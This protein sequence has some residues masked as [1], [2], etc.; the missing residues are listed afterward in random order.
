MKKGAGLV[1]IDA[2]SEFSKVKSV[3]T[4]LCDA[5][6]RTRDAKD[7]LMDARD[8]LGDASLYA[9]LL[10]KICDVFAAFTDDNA[11][12]FCANKSAESK[13]FLRGAGASG[14]RRRRWLIASSVL[15]RV[16]A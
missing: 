5:L 4:D 6:Y 2:G 14:T 16:Y 12:I 3:K 9:S 11:S 8:N 7:T 10:A 13:R 1:M 15:R